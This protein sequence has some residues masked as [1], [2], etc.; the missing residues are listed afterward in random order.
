MGGTP[1][2]ELGTAQGAG[3]KARRTFVHIPDIF[4]F[5]LNR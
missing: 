4:N 2:S 3:S 5:G 1:D